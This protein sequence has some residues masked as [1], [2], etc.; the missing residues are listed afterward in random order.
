MLKQLKI[1]HL[2]PTFFSTDSTVGG[3]E[4]YVYN[5]CRAISI[6]ATQQDYPAEQVIFSLGSDPRV[7]LYEGLRVVILENLAPHSNAMETLPSGLWAAL[8]GFDLV[9][10]HQ[11]LTLFGAYCMA[12]AKSLA[13]P[14][15]ST[16]LGG[17]EDEL[18]LAGRGLELSSRVLSISQYA[19]SLTNSS[20]SGE[21]LVLI[22]PIDC[23]YF[24]P[25]PNVARNKSTV[26]CVGRILPHKGFDR[27]IEALP[28]LLTLTIVGQIYDKNYFK[29]LQKL[30]MDKN[31]VFLSKAEDDQLLELYQT[32]G[33]F[34]QPSTHIDCYGNKISKPELMGLTT[35]EAMACGMPVV[36]SDAGSLPEL[37]TSPELGQVFSNRAELEDILNR[38]VASEWP[39]TNQRLA[40][41]VETCEAYS[42]STVGTKM[43]T[44]Y[45]EVTMSASKAIQFT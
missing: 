43:L 13:I 36:V 40:L 42:F 38:F 29:L 28:P 31:V 39:E 37:I 12:I 23:N 22:G 30:A 1:A 4:R 8:K 25:D 41:R 24:K 7:F 26:L 15:I 11:S 45:Q 2:T 19:K 16:D 3:G 33:L 18:M 5:I 32:S 14:V 9:H 34:I 17:G 20:F 44:F 10:I 6:A 21:D 27:V 35:L